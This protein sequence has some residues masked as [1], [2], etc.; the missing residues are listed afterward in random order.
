MISEKLLP[1]PFVYCVMKCINPNRSKDEFY[2]DLRQRLEKEHS[3]PSVYMFKFIVPNSNKLHAQVEA[4]FGDEAQIS[5]RES[6][7]GNYVSITAK[8]MMLSAENIIAR[9]R[10]ASKI[11]GIVSL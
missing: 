3:F 6:S 2:S 5:I 9:Y 10:S 8:E 7:K 4:L 1:E 11:E